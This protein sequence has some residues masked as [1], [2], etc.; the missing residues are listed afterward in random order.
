LNTSKKEKIEF[1]KKLDQDIF[2][3]RVPLALIQKLTLE[4]FS[5]K[6]QI[7]SIPSKIAGVKA[8]KLK[9]DRKAFLAKAKVAVLKA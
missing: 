5:S 8:G 1:K 2:N 4:D 6:V 7:Q 3:M 9:F